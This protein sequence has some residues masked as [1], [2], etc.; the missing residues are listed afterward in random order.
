M[1]K[2]EKLYIKIED[3]VLLKKFF[4]NQ[5]LV[6]IEDLIALIDDLNYDYE[7]IKEEYTDLIEDVRDNYKFIGTKEAIGYDERT[8]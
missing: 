7:K 5:D 3:Y 2:V 6:S 8:W 4:K 1:I